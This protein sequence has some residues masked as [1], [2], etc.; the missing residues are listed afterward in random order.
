MIRP[1]KHECYDLGYDVR[2]RRNRG[3][4]LCTLPPNVTLGDEWYSVDDILW[5]SLSSQEWRDVPSPGFVGPVQHL[6]MDL[7]DL[8][9]EAASI[10][11][12]N[13]CDGSKS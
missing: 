6:W 1:M 12:P 10:P 8:R 2:S 4:M 5:P 11:L 3:K 13:R 9:G 7:D